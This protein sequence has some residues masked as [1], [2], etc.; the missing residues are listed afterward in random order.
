MKRIMR[1]IKAFGENEAGLPDFP[2][3]ISGITVT[4]V[5]ILNENGCSRCFPHGYEC[6]NSTIGNAQ[7]CWKRHRRH[8]WK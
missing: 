6:I 2:R 4:R 7:R 1:L 8:Q 3:K 5:M